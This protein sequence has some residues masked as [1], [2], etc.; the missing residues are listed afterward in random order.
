M[1]QEIKIN[2]READLA[3][4]EQA[5]KTSRGSIRKAVLEVESFFMC[6]N[7]KKA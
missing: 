3:L 2:K 1:G 5:L 6:E 4:I 7:D